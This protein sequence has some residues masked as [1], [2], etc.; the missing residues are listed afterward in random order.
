MKYDDGGAAADGRKTDAV[1]AH[2]GLAESRIPFGM[3]HPKGGTAA[4]RTC[5]MFLAHC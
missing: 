2:K 5:G 1:A 3:M 4:S